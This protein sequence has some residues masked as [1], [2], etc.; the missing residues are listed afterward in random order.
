M[1]RIFNLFITLLI[2]LCSYCIVIKASLETTKQ[3]Q[4]GT[5]KR[6]TSN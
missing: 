4:L 3:R 1:Y 5:E 2:Y 6:W